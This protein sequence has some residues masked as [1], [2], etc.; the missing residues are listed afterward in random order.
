MIIDHDAKKT[1]IG[2][3]IKATKELVEKANQVLG[4]HHQRNLYNKRTDIVLF[5]KLPFL[6]SFSSPPGNYQKEMRTLGIT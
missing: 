1:Y 4:K 2:E 5:D 6:E 3:L